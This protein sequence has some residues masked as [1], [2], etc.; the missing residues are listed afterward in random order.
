[1][2]KTNQNKIMKIQRAPKKIYPYKSHS[3]NVASW[4]KSCVL[5]FAEQ[6]AISLVYVYFLQNM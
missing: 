3:Q 4:G 6:T 1:M 2:G 5:C